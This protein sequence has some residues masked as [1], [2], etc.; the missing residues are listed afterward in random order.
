M[1][2]SKY[3]FDM[4]KTSLLIFIF[5]STIFLSFS[6]FFPHEAFA[7]EANTVIDYYGDKEYVGPDPYG[8]NND[9]TKI[10]TT[11]AINTNPNPDIIQFSKSDSYGALAPYEKDWYANND[12]H[13]IQPPSPSPLNKD[14]SIYSLLV[15]LKRRTFWYAWK[16]HSNDYSNYK[17]FKSSWNP[18]NSIR[19]EILKDVKSGF[20]SLSSKK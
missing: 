6:V 11:P 2:L 14:N 5:L 16:I 10:S 13:I 4:L 15:V 1:Y 12:P 17:D 19:K 3:Y 20:K 8:H 7:M 18:R 9:P